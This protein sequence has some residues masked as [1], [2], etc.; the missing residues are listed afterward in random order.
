MKTL[1]LLF[2]STVNRLYVSTEGFP[3]T[4]A[5]ESATLTR[6]GPVNTI[7]DNTSGAGFLQGKALLQGLFMASDP[8]V[9]RYG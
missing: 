2:H 3:T 4:F 7:A 1:P 6:S 9:G 8:V 5:S